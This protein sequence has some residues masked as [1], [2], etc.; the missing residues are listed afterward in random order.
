MRSGWVKGALAATAIAGAL[1]SAGC[2][3]VFGTPADNPPPAENPLEALMRQQAAAQQAAP[4]ADPAAMQTFLTQNGKA[5]GVQYKVLHSGPAGGPTLADGDVVKVN[6][7][8]SLVDGTPFDA[9]AQHGGPAEFTV[10]G[11]L[12]P[13][14]NEALKLMRVGDAFMVYMP[15]ALGYGDHPQPGSPIPAGSVLIFKL[16]IVSKAGGNTANG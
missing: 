1:A 6:Y 5:P 15:P 2:G 11:D 3:K 14:F 4:P 7:E 12:V 10:G 13:G 16:E 9:S 8:G